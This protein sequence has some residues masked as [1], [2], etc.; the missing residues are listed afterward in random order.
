MKSTAR[1]DDG[2]DDEHSVKVEPK[3]RPEGEQPR[4]RFQE[5]FRRRRWSRHFRVLR[6][7]GRW[8]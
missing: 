3:A 4:R 8:E 7:T 6:W 5:E 2:K 1:R